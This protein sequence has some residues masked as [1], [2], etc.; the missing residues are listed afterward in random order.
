MKFLSP[1]AILP[2]Y[3]ANYIFIALAPKAPK[4]AEA[5]AITTFKIL[6]QT[7]FFIVLNF[8]LFTITWLR[9]L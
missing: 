9:S 7:F 8:F 3:R 4:I 5:T 1:I 2:F 6:S